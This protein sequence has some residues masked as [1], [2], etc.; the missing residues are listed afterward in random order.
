MAKRVGPRAGRLRAVRCAAV[1]GAAIV[2]LAACGGSS[3]ETEST[4]S[5]RDS[6]GAQ[7]K[8][9]SA[10]GPDAADT[11]APRSS[12]SS[13]TR[14]TQTS[15][16]FTPAT[17]QKAGVLETTADLM[18]HRAELLG[19]KNAHVAVFGGGITAT[20]PGK[21]EEKLT[22]LGE[23][24]RLEFRPVRGESAA[25][26]D[27][28]P[29]ATAPATEPLTACSTKSGSV[30]ANRYE[31]GPA[32]V[33]GGDVSSARARYDEQGG[34][35]WLVDIAFTNRGA[36]RFTDLTT[37]LSRQQ[38]P[39]NEVAIVLDGQVLSAPSV[40]STIPN[41]KVQIS[42]TFTRASARE[43]AALLSAGALPVDMKVSSVTDIDDAATGRDASTGD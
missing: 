5:A 40:S 2:G 3:G 26:A 41:G 28:C 11:S 37:E 1:A 18:R 20:A 30:P 31:L 8:G 12:A 13:A 9:S 7:D 23:Q 25:T 22:A 24:A 17:P 42:G 16:V 14:A 4:E 38:P 35:G 32:A 34:S 21:A 29:A 43:L 27:R 15:V 10:Q 19:L 6:K 36:Q 33:R 39:T